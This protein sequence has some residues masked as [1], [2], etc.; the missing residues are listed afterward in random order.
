MDCLYNCK[1]PSLISLNRLGAV[2][3]IRKG[4]PEPIVCY[5]C[6]NKQIS[7]SAGSLLCKTDIG[8]TCSV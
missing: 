8:Q 5:F 3:P 1:T 6:K 7:T 2:V 4:I